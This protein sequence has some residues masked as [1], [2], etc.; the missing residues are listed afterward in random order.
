MV[1]GIKG[2][3]VLNTAMIGRNL[4]PQKLMTTKRNLE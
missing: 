4:E 1:K 2:R 3:N